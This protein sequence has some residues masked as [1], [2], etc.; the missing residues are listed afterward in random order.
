MFCSARLLGPPTPGLPQP[1]RAVHPTMITER[2]ACLVCSTRQFAAMINLRDVFFQFHGGLP[3]VPNI[4]I[5]GRQF[6][7]S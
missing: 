7:G 5:I 2:V 3:V 1:P 6:S 4:M